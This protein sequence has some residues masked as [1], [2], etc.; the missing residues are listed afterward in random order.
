MKRVTWAA[1]SAAVLLAACGPGGGTKMTG[2]VDSC[3]VLRAIDAPGLIGV[4]FDPPEGQR[5]VEAGDNAGKM[6]SCSLTSAAPAED[7]GSLAD[8]GAQLRNTWFVTLMAWTW[9]NAE[10]AKGYMDSMRQSDAMGAA[11]VDVSGL[12]D[13]AVWNGMMHARAGNV[14]L[15]L[16]V[17]GP[18]DEEGEN[19]EKSLETELTKRALENLR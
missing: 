6:S 7:P 17:R 9:P 15:S 11:S 14:T 18:A 2:M 1:A 12:G 19:S 3:G 16:D 8:V 4:E 5:E 13:E 10:S